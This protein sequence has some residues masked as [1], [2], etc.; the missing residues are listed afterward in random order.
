MGSVLLAR[1]APPTA[2]APIHQLVPR[3]V[4][5]AVAADHIWAS[6]RVELRPADLGLTDWFRW[7]RDQSAA[8]EPAE[9]AALGLHL[10]GLETEYLAVMVDGVAVPL[11]AARVRF[12]GS[13]VAALSLTDSVS[14]RFE[15][16]LELAL[17]SGAHR[18]V[19]YDRPAAADGIV[20]IRLSLAR[21]LRLANFQ[22][23]RAER[24]SQRRLEAVVSRASPAVWGELVVEEG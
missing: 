24:R 3:Q 5:V 16:R 18:V 15:T 20:P 19:L 21:G 9:L 2:S 23:A 7:D 11:V 8:L 6:V 13:P 14:F 10:R 12:A 1:A 4:Q 17:E 22:G